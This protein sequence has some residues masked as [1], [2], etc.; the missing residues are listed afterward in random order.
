MKPDLISMILKLFCYQYVY[1][2]PN[3]EIIDDLTINNL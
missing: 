1:I 3:L 2:L